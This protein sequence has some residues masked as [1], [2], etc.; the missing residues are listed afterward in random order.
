MITNFKLDV[1]LAI[2]TIVSKQLGVTHRYIEF[3]DYLIF[4]TSDTVVGNVYL[5]WHCDELWISWHNVIR[6]VYPA[7]PNSIDI[8]IK[9]VSGSSKLSE[10]L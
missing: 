8:I 5:E 9:F 2:A 1:L 4:Q 3:H 10:K 7:D 6:I